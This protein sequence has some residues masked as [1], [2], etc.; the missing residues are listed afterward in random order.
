MKNKRFGRICVVVALCALLAV[1][2]FAYCERKPSYRHEIMTVSNWD[3]DTGLVSLLDREGNLWNVY[4]TDRQIT[5]FE[6]VNVIVNDNGT[7]SIYDDII[8]R[9]YR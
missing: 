6:K 2:V 5:Q 9:F 7:R 1:C 4:T 8:V 3:M